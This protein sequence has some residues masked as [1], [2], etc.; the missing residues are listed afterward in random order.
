MQRGGART[1]PRRWPLA[2]PPSAPPEPGLRR[3]LGGWLGLAAAAAVLLCHARRRQR[4]PELEGEEGKNLISPVAKCWRQT[5]S[6]PR[7]A[8]EQGGLRYPGGALPAGQMVSGAA[9]VVALGRERAGGLGG[10]A[11]RT[12]S[13]RAKLKE[14]SVQ[15]K[16]TQAIIRMT[17]QTQQLITIQI[18]PRR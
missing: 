9:Q 3:F 7:A 4:R 14:P 12:R 1:L 15:L 6:S 16:G 13:H 8:R 5:P 17:S 18:T 2:R 11:G 10:K